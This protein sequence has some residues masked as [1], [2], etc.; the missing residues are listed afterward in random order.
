MGCYCWEEMQ[1]LAPHSA[2]HRVTDGSPRKS[3][4]WRA[5]GDWE[6][7]RHAESS[8]AVVLVTDLEHRGS[9]GH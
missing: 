9:H 6:V 8:L 2:K 5:A 1:S 7:G 4:E 3:V